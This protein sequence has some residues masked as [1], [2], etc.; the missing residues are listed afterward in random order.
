[1]PSF[2]NPAQ[3]EGPL[4]TNH[5]EFISSFVMSNVCSTAVE[6][7]FGSGSSLVMF[8][9]RVSSLAPINQR[10]LSADANANAV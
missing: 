6:H 9:I 7:L 10:I 2:L 8:R 4:D 1:M 5:L 3:K